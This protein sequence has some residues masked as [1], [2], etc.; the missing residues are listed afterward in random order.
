[1]TPFTVESILG[2]ARLLVYLTYRDRLPALVDWL[3]NITRIETLERREEGPKVHL[4]NRWE[5]TGRVPAFARK[6]VRPDML[7]WTDTA[8]WD[9]DAW[10]VDWRF[11]IHAVENLVDVSGT[12]TFFEEGPSRTRLRIDA[13]LHID[14]TRIPGLPASVGRLAAPEAERFI[15]KLVKPNLVETAKGVDR[16]LRGK[17]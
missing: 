9:D 10:R 14:G 5:A 15:I 13:T 6:Y 2:H 11:R 12:N 4:L 3:P 8:D 16:F 17:A 7:A 1:M